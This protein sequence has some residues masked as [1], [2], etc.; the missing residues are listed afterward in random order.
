[1]CL[2]ICQLLVVHDT[3]YKHW[4]ILGEA[5]IN[6]VIDLC[7][8]VKRVDRDHRGLRIRDLGKSSHACVWDDDQISLSRSAKTRQPKRYTG[9]IPTET[10]K[11]SVLN[12]RSYPPHDHS[13]VEE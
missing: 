5:S 2:L 11:A 9:K 13:S 7:N 8:L 1:M 3:Q 4:D 10:R 12:R 6:I